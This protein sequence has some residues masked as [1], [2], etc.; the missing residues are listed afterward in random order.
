MKIGAFNEYG[1]RINLM[2]C[3]L[4]KFFKEKEKKYKI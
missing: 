2:L 4:L 1:K 3:F